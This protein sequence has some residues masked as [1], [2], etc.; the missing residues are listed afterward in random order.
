MA[1]FSLPLYR[2]ARFALHSELYSHIVLIPFISLYV[3][4]LKRTELAL[5]SAP[6]PAW[7]VIPLA[8]G[9]ALLTG[10][11]LGRHSGWKPHIEDALACTTA[12]FLAFF[13]G[14]SFLCLG[15]RTVR[16]LAFPLAFLI[17]M[18]PFPRFLLGWIETVLQH[19]SAEAAYAFFIVSGMP[20][21]RTGTAFQLPG[22]SMEVAPQCSGIHSSLVLFI[23][24]LVGGYLLLRKHWSRGVFALAVLPLAILRNGFRIFVLG[25]LCVRVSP[26]WIDSKLHHN[27]GPIFFALSLIPFFLL[28]L[29]L[30]KLETRRR[31]TPPL[32]PLPPVQMSHA[33]G[34]TSGG[35]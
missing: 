12:S 1:A 31:E 13:I 10:Y 3:A 11:W 28:L 19:G 23:T 33:G 32:S 25:Q 2:L 22:I 29:L 21:L 8:L 14:A 35:K 15:L 24:S 7:A 30:R 27:G 5:D 9:C 34:I 16:S 20:V 17:F 18:V 4:R 26:A 6:K